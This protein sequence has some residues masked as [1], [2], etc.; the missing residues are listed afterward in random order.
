[1]TTDDILA[2]I[3]R[4][5]A[6]RG[7]EEY[8]GEAVSQL[9]HALQSAAAGEREGAAAELVVA[10][11]LHDVGHL[12]QPH[13]EDAAERGI[14]DR[15]E[16]LGQRFLQKHFGPAVT[17][18]VRL[19]VAAKRY[20]CA[21]EPEYLARLSPASRRSLEL[22]GG[23]MSATE[24]AAFEGEEFYRSATQLRRWDDTAKV[25]GL[26]T[27]PLGHFRDLIRKAFRDR[28]SQTG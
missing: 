17:E 23:P 19:H 14:D 25:P 26:P 4:L 28:D 7:A 18:P 24:V 13:G 5:F 8:H 6:D 9:E 10:A 2:R 27:P 11:L 1:M 12:I 3:D 21:V 20:L 16:S 22:Q 15:H